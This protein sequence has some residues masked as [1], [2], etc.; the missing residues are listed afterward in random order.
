VQDQMIAEQKGGAR[1]PAVRLHYLDWLR[2]LA[3]LMVFLFHAVHP[4]DF[5][6]WQIKNAQQSEIITIVLTLL[7]LWGMPFF[8]LVAGAASWFALRRRSARQYVSERLNRL[9]IPFIAGSLLF[10]PLQYYLEWMNRTQLGLVSVSF[11]EFLRE[12]IPPF[13]PLTLRFPCFSPRWFGVAGFHLWFVGFL[14]AFALITLPLLRWLQGETGRRLVSRLARLCE[15]RGGIL[16]FILPLLVVQLAPRP[17]FTLEHDWHDFLFQMAFF[18]LGYLLFADERIERAVRRDWRLLLALG[19]AIALGLLAAYALGIPV[20]DWGVDPS[21]PQ[22]YV[23]MALITPV[24]F[25][26]TLTMLFVGMRFLDFTNRWLRYGQE[27]ALPF[28]VLH[29]PVI[30]VIAF[31][32]VQWNAGI[33]IKLPVVVVSSFLVTIGLYEL[34]VR[35]VR[36]LRLAFGIKAHSSD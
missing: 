31:F 36:L 3:I 30:V 10:S 24:A 18:V 6:T 16:F 11:L 29:Q 7:G 9:L 23:I 27:A 15:R 12:E 17:F 21:V 5:G 8:F 33:W 26:F 4:F 13:S 32:V 2:V 35:R 20:M 14:F 22:Y 28:F 34:I 1:L 25:C 19:T